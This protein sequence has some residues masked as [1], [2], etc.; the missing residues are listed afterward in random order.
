[1]GT[2]VS[3][4]RDGKERCK[5]IAIFEILIGSSGFNDE[6]AKG[7]KLEA[8]FGEKGERVQCGER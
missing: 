8:R 6:C 2:L 4:G 5:K 1:M 3:E 7:K